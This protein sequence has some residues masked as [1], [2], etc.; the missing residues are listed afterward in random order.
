MMN[1]R[2]TGYALRIV[3][4]GYLAYLGVRLLLQM[5]EEKP[6]NMVV[7]S[8][9][10]VLFIIIGGGYALYSIK[11]VIDISRADREEGDAQGQ[12]DTEKKRPSSG[13]TQATFV[14]GIRTEESEAAPKPERAPETESAPKPERAPAAE[15][16]PKPERT[17]GTEPAPKPDAAPEAGTETE[18][19]AS[20]QASEGAALSDEE[21]ENDYEEK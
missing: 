18:A 13:I 5:L 8:V 6:S 19:A 12:E 14:T 11:K 2:K 15:P 1:N 7:M 16:A 10:A 21:I 20:D 17:S 9:A 3:L 4:G